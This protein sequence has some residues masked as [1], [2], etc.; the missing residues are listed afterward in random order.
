VCTLVE[1][2]SFFS[3]IYPL[4][5]KTEQITHLKEFKVVLMMVSADVAHMWLVGSSALGLFRHVIFI[6]YLGS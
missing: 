1:A 3:I 5:F 2:R 4:T 6:E